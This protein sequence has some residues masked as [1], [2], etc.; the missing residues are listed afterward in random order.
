MDFFSAMDISASGLRLQRAQMNVVSM[1]LANAGTT[2]SAE[3]GPYRKRELVFGAVPYRK[4]FGDFLQTS[5]DQ[6]P[7]QEAKV[8]GVV[9]SNVG[10]RKVHDPS[11]P[12]ADASGD[13]LLPN[14]SV[15][16]EMVKMMA[17]TRSYESNVAA[18]SAAK[19]MALKAIDIGSR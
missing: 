11:H 8:L 4:S 15:M 12:D 5:L 10:L 3:G 17:A 1:N 19:G 2:R 6:V 18:I 7:L 16:E 9:S 13:V 14:V